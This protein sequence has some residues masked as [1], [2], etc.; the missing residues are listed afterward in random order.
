LVNLDVVAAGETDDTDEEWRSLKLPAN[1]VGQNYH[2][3]NIKE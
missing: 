1:V 2:S 3:N